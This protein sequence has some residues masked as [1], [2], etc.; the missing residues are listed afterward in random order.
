MNVKFKKDKLIKEY[1]EKG[2]LEQLNKML[3]DEEVGIRFIK[4]SIPEKTNDKNFLI[5]EWKIVEEE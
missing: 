4:A 5:L 3:K 2:F 1:W